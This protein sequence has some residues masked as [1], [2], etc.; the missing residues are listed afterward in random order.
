MAKVLTAVYFVLIINVL[1]Y[2]NE[3]IKSVIHTLSF[4]NHNVY[5]HIYEVTFYFNLLSHEKDC[6]KKKKSK[7]LATVWWMSLYFLN[8]VNKMNIV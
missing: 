6:L 5:F 4:N 8:E 1:F 7:I 3:K 2:A